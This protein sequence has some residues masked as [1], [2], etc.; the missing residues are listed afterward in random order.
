MHEQR[1]RGLVRPAP[2]R[3]MGDHPG[4]GHRRPRRDHRPARR[5]RSAGLDRGRRRGARRGRAGS[6]AGRLRRSLAR[7][8]PR[9]PDR[10]GPGGRA[11][12]R[13]QGGLGGGDRRADRAVHAPGGAGDDPAAPGGAP[14][15]GH[16][17]GRGCGQVAFAR[18]GLVREAGR[19]EHAGVARRAA[20]GDGE[21]G[22]GSRVR[23]G[24]LS[25][26]LGRLAGSG[27]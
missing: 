9:T 8:D 2:A 12:V 24:C 27:C 20:P 25:L 1:D 26:P 10:R 23:S 14:G 19:Q 22:R 21:R 15:A 16:P 17:G 11:P 7:A 5:G 4:E 13:A 18:A 6:G 3:G